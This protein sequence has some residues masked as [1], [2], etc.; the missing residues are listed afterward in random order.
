M[1]TSVTEGKTS[2]TPG[3]WMN[4]FSEPRSVRTLEPVW[5]KQLTRLPC[6]VIY[7]KFEFVYTTTSKIGTQL[8]LTSSSSK[9]K[10]CPGSEKVFN[11]FLGLSNAFPSVQIW[12]LIIMRWQVYHLGRWVWKV[13]RFHLS[14]THWWALPLNQKQRNPPGLNNWLGW[15]AKWYT[16]SSNSQMMPLAWR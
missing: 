4:A 9:V 15:L 16:S 13:V 12:L 7:V 5:A 10:L 8:L 3:H 6:S 11:E 14:V 2:L 1:W